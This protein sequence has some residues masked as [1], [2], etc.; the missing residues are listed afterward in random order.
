MTITSFKSALHS[1]GFIV[2]LFFSIQSFAQTESINGTVT[3]GEGKPIAG[4]TVKIKGANK[5]TTTKE[6][7]TFSFSNVPG[8]GTLIISHIAYTTMEAPYT[9]GKEVIVALKESVA[10]VDEVVVTGVFDKRTR[11]SSSVAI[12]TISSK[13]IDR[14]APSSAAD[15][16]RQVPGV[17]VNNAR[18]EVANTVYSRGISAGSIDNANGYFYTSL[19]EDGLPVTNVNIS[20]DYFL[21]ADA[22]I[23]TVEAVR[24]GTASILGANAPGGLFNYISKTGGT[25]FGGEVRGR[26]GLEGDGKNP[27]YRA[28]VNL[29]GPL[30][31]DKTWTYNLGGFYRRSNG[32]RY[33]GYPMNNGGQ[34]KANVVKTYQSGSF[35][36]YAKMLNDRNATMEFIPTI[37]WDNPKVVP[38]LSTT[39]SYYLP[40][41]FMQI[42][43]NNTGTRIFDTR[44]KTHSTDKAIGFNWTQ[45]FGTGWTFKNDARY[46]AK[47]TTNNTPAVVTPFSTTSI[48]FYAIPHLLGRFGTYTFKDHVT[49]Q[50]LGTVTQAPNIVNGQFAGFN[51]IPGANNNFPGNNVQPNSLFFLPLFYSDFKINEFMDQFTFSKKLKNMNFT[52][53]GFYAHSNVDRIGGQEDLG[54][55]FGTIQDKPH[56][57]DITLQGFDGQTYQVTDPNGIVDVGRNGSSLSDAT[58]TQMALF[59]GH[60]WQ[61]TDRLNLDW[62]VRFE[63]TGVKGNNTPNVPNS[64]VNDPTYGGRDG[65]PLTLYDNG[66]GT[67]GTPLDYD[68]SVSTFSYSAGLNYKINDQFAIY[69]RYSNGNKAP[70]IKNYFSALTPFAI[71][72]LNTDAQKTEQLEFG[73]KAK[74]GKLNLFVTPF[75]SK[76]SNVPNL[77]TFT[78]TNGANYQPAVQYAKYKTYGLEV[79]ANYAFTDHFSVRGIATLQ[80]SEATEFTTWIANAPG[81]QDDVLADYSGN[82]TDNNARVILGLTPTYSA[83]NFYASLNW[84]YLGA[85]QANV[86]N[87]FR[88]PAF[89]QFDL[90]I[91][92]DVS[93]R[94]GLQANVNNLFNTYGVYGWSGPGGFPMALD[95]QGFTPEYIKANPDAVYATQGS[96]P[97]AYFLTVSYK[98]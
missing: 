5:A 30:S 85:R 27:F 88:M 7:G 45:N 55:G 54:L 97:R 92:Y 29:G 16:L 32:P 15:L 80:H 38:G 60:N 3:D 86:L 14:L 61:L 84:N 77:Q 57:T 70:E 10:Q 37:G 69:G 36:F 95:R 46:S 59:F 89:S 11:M 67:A 48:V 49:G 21:R 20:T 82:E 65:N 44:D 52:F 68:K 76:L 79:E 1:I 13:Q 62:G 50:V 96:M 72:T 73:F 63:N 51:F 87:A 26:F 6:Q 24:G 90:S 18:G 12:S 71:Q 34:V 43:I 56:L 40:D 19:Q 35:K 17:Y 22:T 2:L 58:Q 93:K 94:V 83:N 66:G 98:F 42:P 41:M 81:K 53:G 4:A 75:Y 9:S 31:K 39:D 47:R 23:K 74:T 78:D 25:K 33:P 91:G 28:D 64:K 8:S